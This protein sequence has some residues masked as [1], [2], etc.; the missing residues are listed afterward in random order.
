MGNSWRGNVLVTLIM[1]GMFYVS[2]AWL[3]MEW[4]A[5]PLINLVAGLAAYFN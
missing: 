3:G 1:A 4:L 5:R 2:Y